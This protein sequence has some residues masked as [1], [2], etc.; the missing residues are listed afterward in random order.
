VDLNDGKLR[1]QF[2]QHKE[3]LEWA[4]SIGLQ[5]QSI[6]FAEDKVSAEI[7]FISEGIY[8]DVEL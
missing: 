3:K 7:E 2:Q 5:R 8:T 6:V 4:K 1:E